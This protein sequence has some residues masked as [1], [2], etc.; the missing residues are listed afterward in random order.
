[1]SHFGPPSAPSRTASEAL[2]A[3]HRLVG[4]RRAVQVDGGAAGRVLVEG[5]V[6]R[7][8][9]EDLDGGGGHLGADPVAGQESDVRHGS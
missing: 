2:Q 9:V 6:V 7:D 8:G 1:M 3:V 4:E 5:Q